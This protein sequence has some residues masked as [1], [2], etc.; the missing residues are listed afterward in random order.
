MIRWRSDYAVGVQEIDREH[1]HLF[2]L[3]ESLFE[4]IRCGHGR[5]IL[6]PLLDALVEFACCHFAHEE[7]L[8]E[9]IGYPHHPEHRQ[10]HADLRARVSQMRGRYAAGETGMHMELLQ[11]LTEWLSCHTTTS[12]RR[13]GTYMRKHGL[14]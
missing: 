12:D 3:A 6:G 10:Q 9:Q 13:I 7:E 8:M 11:F 2:A 4:G 14:A 5:D 1:Q